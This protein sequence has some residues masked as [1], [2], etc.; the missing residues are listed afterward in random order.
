LDGQ[1][2]FITGAARG[3]GRSHAVLFAQE[4]ADIIALDTVEQIETVAYPTA[5]PGDLEET[6]R[7]VEECD[8][9][10][11]ARQGDVRDLQRLTEVVEEG[12][13]ELGRLD[14]VIANAGINT[15]EPTLT[16]DEEVWQTMIDINLTGVWKTLRASVPHI[17]TGERGGAVVLTSSLATTLTLEGC[18]HYTAAKAGIVGLM[19]VLAKEVGTHN[20]RV[21]TVHPTT[22]ATQ[23]VL[24]EDNY[25]IFRPE[26]DHPTQDDFEAGLRELHRLPL[27][28]MDPIDISNA[29]LYL[30]S[31]SGRYVTGSTLDIGAGD[32]L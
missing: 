16:M 3:Q 20:I 8:R 1:V 26:L 28:L 17:I 31:E 23:M 18:A 30:V 5:Q 25:H 12:V 7:L 32:E 29:I 6:V 13:A 21:N 24:H 10:I 9:R 14:I 15:I 27:A 4:G 2:A 11:V 22:T 19:R